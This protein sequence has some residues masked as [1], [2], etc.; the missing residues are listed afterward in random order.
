MGRPNRKRRHSESEEGS[1]ERNKTLELEK[2]LR[3]LERHFRRES[4]SSSPKRVRSSKTL[5]G[6]QKRDNGEQTSSRVEEQDKENSPN[7]N[8]LLV[9]DP[10]LDQEILNCLG[11]DP[12][13]GKVRGI[14]LHKALVPR[15]KNI[16]SNGM[17]KEIKTELMVKYPIPVNCP[18]LQTPIL[19]PEIAQAVSDL[20]LKKEKY[21]TA[22]QT[23]L[24]AGLTALGMALNMILADEEEVFLTPQL[25]TT[26]MNIAR[27]SCIDANLFGSDFGERLKAAKESNNN[28]NYR[29]PPRGKRLE[30][31]WAISQQETIELPSPST[32]ETVLTEQLSD[33]AFRYGTFNSFRSA[34]ALILPGNVGEDHQIRRFLRGVARLRPQRPKYNFVWDPQKVLIYLTSYMPN[35]QLSLKKLTEKLVTL[36]ALTTSQ[37]MQTLSLIRTKNV[38]ISGGYTNFNKRSNKNQWTKFRSTMPK[39]SLFS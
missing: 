10:E 28:L 20:S 21:Q 17:T 9:S 30:A 19:N 39:D 13:A 6:S 35:E 25:N 33:K 18:G 3:K 26:A 29:G 5:K 37:R 4:Y 8:I 1:S 7:N 38:I 11:E 23:Q 32:T 22:M 36:L 27:T 2:R 12:E 14:E 34:L 24:G 16:L 31:L 15:W